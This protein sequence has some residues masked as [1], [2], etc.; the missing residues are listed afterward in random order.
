MN[1][2]KLITAVVVLGVLLWFV[3]AGAGWLLLEV[4]A[5]NRLLDKLA[6]AKSGVR[7]S[8]IADQLGLQERE[9]SELKE[10]LEWGTVK[11]ESFCRGK[12]LFRFY[13][14]T[15]PCRSVDVYTDANDVIVYAT[16][17]Q[18]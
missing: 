13:A 17:K 8:Q 14:V 1:K 3:S 5:S 16:W 7:V 9:F 15:P 18:E 11:D 4:R 6:L 12:K 2:H 10:V